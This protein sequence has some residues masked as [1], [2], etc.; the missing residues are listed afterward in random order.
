M[1]GR[2][3]TPG[4]WDSCALERPVSELA[5]GPAGQAFGTSSM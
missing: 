3:G 4:S 5:G 1:L 2:L